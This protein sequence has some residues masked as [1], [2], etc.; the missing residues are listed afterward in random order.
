M[1]YDFNMLVNEDGTPTK[2]FMSL[3]R[4]DKDGVKANNLFLGKEGGQWVV[5]PG[6][7]IYRVCRGTMTVQSG[8]HYGLDTATAHRE[9]LI[10][11]GAKAVYW[12]GRTGKGFYDLEKALAFAKEKNVDAAAIQKVEGS[13]I[14]SEVKVVVSYDRPKFG[15]P[16]EPISL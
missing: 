12:V 15:T 8:T 16:E 6:K 2:E 13:D 7:P 9:K 14:S 5:K 1:K 4:K 3:W 10:E 11:T